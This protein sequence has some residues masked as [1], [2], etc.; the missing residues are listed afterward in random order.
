MNKRRLNVADSEPV[1]T[2]KYFRLDVP[3]RLLPA[4]FFEATCEELA[5]RLLG[6]ILCR[7]IGTRVAR[8]RIVETESYLGV[9]DGAS[10]SFRGRRTERNAAMY[11]APGTVY[12]YPIYGMYECV[13][14]SSL[15]EG[16]AVL[17]RAIG[18]WICFYCCFTVLLYAKLTL[19]KN[20][21]LW[22]RFFVCFWLK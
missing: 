15:E 10:H 3:L 4:A 5:K 19:G 11:M 17:I 18:T 20:C 14:I 13:N 21:C 2:S 6:K 8:G 9:T 1:T 7:R 12:V 16:S 22:Y